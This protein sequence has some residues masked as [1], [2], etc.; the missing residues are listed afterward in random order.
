MQLNDEKTIISFE[1]IF[2]EDTLN[3][4]ISRIETMLDENFMMTNHKGIT[5]NKKQ[6]LESLP[7]IKYL[8]HKYMDIEVMTKSEMAF[9]TGIAIMSASI[10]NEIAKMNVK[11]MRIYLK[12]N[13]G[14]KAIALQTTSIMDQN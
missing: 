12:K 13:E 4:D 8:V 9:V 14:W 3:G 1:R 2:E 10:G 6:Y 11:Y 7:G 5:R